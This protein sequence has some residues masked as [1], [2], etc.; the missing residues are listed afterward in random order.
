[1]SEAKGP[2][3]LVARAV[4]AYLRAFAPGECDGPPA[5]KVLVTPELLAEI[6]R[7]RDLVRAHALHHAAS[8]FVGDLE[9][10]DQYEGECWNVRDERLWVGAYGFSFCGAPKHCDYRV[11][12]GLVDFEQAAAWAAALASGGPEAFF[13]DVDRADVVEAGLLAAGGNHG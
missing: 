1:M 10:A 7:L 2:S 6:E 11:E 4:T 13:C 12:T 5:V 8:I 9:W 3:A